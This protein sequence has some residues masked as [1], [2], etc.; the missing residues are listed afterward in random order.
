MLKKRTRTQTY[1]EEE[2]E[3]EPARK[4]HKVHRAEVTA[5]AI[6]GS[7]LKSVEVAPKT[8]NGIPMSE[9]VRLRL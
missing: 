7:P 8:T 1:R 4:R 5:E 2:S 9:E 3:E 6:R